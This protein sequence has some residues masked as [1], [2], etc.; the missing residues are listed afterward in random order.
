M[1]TSASTVVRILKQYPISRLAAVLYLL[2]VHLSIYYLVGRLQR[3][4]IAES[5]SATSVLPHG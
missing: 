5:A 1:D 2:F 4:A 3:R